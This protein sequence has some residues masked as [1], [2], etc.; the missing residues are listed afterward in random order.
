MSSQASI[1]MSEKLRIECENTAGT[2]KKQVT[3]LLVNLPEFIR[4]HIHVDPPSGCWY[5]TGSKFSTG[6]ALIC[7][8]GKLW[9][10]HRFVWTITCGPIP[11]GLKCLHRCDH[12]ACVNPAHLFL[13]TDGDNQRD[14]AAKG[15]HWQQK[16]TACPKGHAYTPEN[17]HRSKLGHRRCKTCMRAGLDLLRQKAAR[18]A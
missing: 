5:W 17:T 18:N 9:K 8:D 10:G 12:P 11:P 2:D 6:Y 13:G 14:K 15:R 1:S 3:S 7:K 4:K 16:K